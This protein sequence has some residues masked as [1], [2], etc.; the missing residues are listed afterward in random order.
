MAKL[1]HL[2]FE[3]WLL[4]SETLSQDE[5]RQLQEHLQSCQACTRLS[6]A[7]REI[8]QELHNAPVLT[9]APGFVSRWQTRLEANRIQSHRRQTFL[10]MFL[11]IGGAMFMLSLL[12]LAIFP[13][14]RS[15]WPVFLAF[16][17]E[18]TSTFMLASVISEALVTVLKAIFEIIPVTQWAAIWVALAGLG[19]LWVVAM[20]RL[21][22][23]RRIPS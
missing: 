3:D 2:P 20:H 4:T 12:G 15:P 21:T 16:L 18:L 9:P 8:D 6:V 17:Y 10:I 14:L 11:C 23:P 5:A 7:L 22:L 1:N 13:V 19:A